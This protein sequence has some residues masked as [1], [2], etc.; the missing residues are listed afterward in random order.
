[1]YWTIARADKYLVILLLYPG[2]VNAI[3]KK[4]Y[5]LNLLKQLAI[6]PFK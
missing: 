5:G 4:V 6:Q 3:G 2:F 1:M